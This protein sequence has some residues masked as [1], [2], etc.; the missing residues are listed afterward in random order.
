M[1]LLL[2]GRQS[3]RTAD[4]NGS[5]GQRLH[6]EFFG[7][8]QCGTT[9]TEAPLMWDLDENVA[10]QGVPCETTYEPKPGAV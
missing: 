5:P 2:E 1:R 10:F 4:A 9:L 8:S 3:H 7:Q 6:H